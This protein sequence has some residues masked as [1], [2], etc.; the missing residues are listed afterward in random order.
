M[1]P[2]LFIL[3]ISFWSSISNAQ[4]FTAIDLADASS[5]SATKLQSYLLKKGFAGG[6]Y[7]TPSEKSFRYKGKKGKA[8][9]DSASREITISTSDSDFHFAYNSSSSAEQEVLKK[10]LKAKGFFGEADFYQKNDISY[11]WDIKR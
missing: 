7:I 1:K 10:N 2:F 5:L 8:I 11:R 6:T 4:S 3:L 9:E